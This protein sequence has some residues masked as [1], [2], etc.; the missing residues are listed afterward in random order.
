MAKPQYDQGNTLSELYSRFPTLVAQ[1]RSCTLFRWLMHIGN[2]PFLI[3]I[4]CPQF[5]LCK[6][7]EILGDSSVVFLMNKYPNWKKSVVATTFHQLLIELEKL[8]SCM[9]KKSFK[10]GLTGLGDCSTQTNILSELES[11]GWYN[12]MH[13][14]AEFSSVTLSCDDEDV[15][16]KHTLEVQFP[17]NFPQSKFTVIHQL[18]D[19]WKPPE[20]DSLSQIYTC[21]TKA[22]HTYGSSWAALRELD[23]L[24]WVLDPECPG[25]QHLYR[26]VVVAPSVS[27]YLNVD[28]TSPLSPPSIKFLGADQR[29]TPLRESMASNMDLWDVEDPL[30]TNLERVLGI[31]LPS[32]MESAKEDWS[33]ECGICYS[34]R[35][36]DQLPTQNCEDS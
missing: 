19:C 18:P 10:M 32:K 9:G 6:E 26:R 34:Y 24:C 1:N 28:P 35:L 20:T 17:S 2:Y 25:P 29:I 22:V 14:D 27:L 36:G 7:F 12:V 30:L 23:R 15:Q 16:V 5:P 11:V 13:L 3:Q 21:W 33:M 4:S 31:E 8:F